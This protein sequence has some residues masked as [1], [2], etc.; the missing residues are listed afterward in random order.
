MKYKEIVDLYDKIRNKF[1]NKT[2]LIK[3][4]DDD[5]KKSL[6]SDYSLVEHLK[7]RIIELNKEVNYM[8]IIG[9]DEKYVTWYLSVLYTLS[10]KNGVTYICVNKIELI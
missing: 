8:W 3:T 6:D 4:F 7:S 10:I 2:I 9:M 5:I 1:E